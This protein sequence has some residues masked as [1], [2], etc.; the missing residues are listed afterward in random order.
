MAAVNHII[1]KY[2]VNKSFAW[3]FSEQPWQYNETD[4]GT[5]IHFLSS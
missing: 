2:A 4:N 1:Q 3:K 5:P